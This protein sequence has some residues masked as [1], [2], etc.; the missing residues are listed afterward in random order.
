MARRKWTIRLQC[1]D[2]N[3]KEWTFYEYDTRREMVESYSFR[4]RNEWTC[5]RHSHV[6]DV[7]TQERTKVVWESAPSRQE[8]FGTFF[9]KG[10]GLIIGTGYYAEAK[11]FP[12]GTKIRITVEAILPEEPQ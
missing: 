3:C 10:S 6:D 2:P 9:G 7:L 8:G 11:D 1:K 4:H 12:V 5:V